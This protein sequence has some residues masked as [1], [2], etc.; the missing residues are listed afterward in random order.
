MSPVEPRPF[1]IGTMGLPSTEGNADLIFLLNIPSALS[2][3][4]ANKLPAA[5]PRVDKKERR[6]QPDFK[7]IHCSVSIIFLAVA[8]SPAAGVDVVGEVTTNALP[9]ISIS[10]SPGIHSNAMQARDRAFSGLQ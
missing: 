9:T 8:Y 4:G 3:A 1:V 2:L 5:A 6:F 10:E 7:F